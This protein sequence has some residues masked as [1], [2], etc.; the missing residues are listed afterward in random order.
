MHYGS[1]QILLSII[2]ITYNTYITF[3]VIYIF[4][5]VIL[6]YSRIRLDIK[7]F[8]I[9]IIFTFGLTFFPIKP[10]IATL[11]FT[12]YN[13][14]GFIHQYLNKILTDNILGLKIIFWILLLIG[15]YINVEIVKRFVFAVKAK[16][17]EKEIILTILWFLFLLIMPF[18]YQVWEK[19]L[20][21]ILPFLVLNIYLLVYPLHKKTSLK[22]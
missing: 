21:M 13:T 20:T 5:I 14:V 9:A 11:A 17:L 6:F 18:S 22:T 12:D 15:I 19:Y 4:P 8:L 3:S 7:N 10:S 1:S 2:L 16:I